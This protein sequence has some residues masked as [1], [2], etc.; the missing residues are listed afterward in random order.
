RARLPSVV[1]TKPITLPFAIIVASVRVSMC[2]GED[3]RGRCDAL[4]LRC[5]A[6]P[7]KRQSAILR[8]AGPVLVR[9]LSWDYVDGHHV[10]EHFHEEDQLVHAVRGVMT[11]RTP[12]GLWV[13]PPRR[14]VWIPSK[15]PHSIDISGAVTMKTLYLAPQLAENLPRDACCV[16]HVSRFME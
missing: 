15:V 14:A 10:P 4:S 1:A 16:L 12:D 5:Q 2:A 13:V 7:R 9:T 6:M 8:G 11:V 3:I